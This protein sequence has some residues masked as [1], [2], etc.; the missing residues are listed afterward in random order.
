VHRLNHLGA[1][2]TEVVTGTSREGFEFELREVG[3][4]MFEGD[5]SNRFELFDEVDLDAALATFDEL[6]QQASS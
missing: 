5:L 1:V 3:L 6:D 2:I 4:L